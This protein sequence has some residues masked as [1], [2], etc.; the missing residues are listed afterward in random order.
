MTQ[1]DLARLTGA[2]VGTVSRWC[3]ELAEPRGYEL[4]AL[5]RVL[6]I[7]A[8]DWYEQPGAEEAA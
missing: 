5:S 3:R 7:P 6:G 2:K 8:A 4:V 1:E